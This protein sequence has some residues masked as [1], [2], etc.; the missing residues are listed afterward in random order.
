M[1]LYQGR[2]LRAESGARGGRR[3]PGRL[4]R[5]LRVLGVIAA[6]A[7][8]AHLPWESMRRSFDRVREVL[9]QGLRMRQAPIV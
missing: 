4:G 6:L 9:V 8:L 2:A 1:T 3:R 7:A 5:M